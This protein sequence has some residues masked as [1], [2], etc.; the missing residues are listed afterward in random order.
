MRSEKYIQHSFAA[1]AAAAAPATVGAI[2]ITT[3]VHS[4]REIKEKEREKSASDSW[5]NYVITIIIS[6][7]SSVV[8]SSVWIVCMFVRFSLSFHCTIH[9]S[10]VL[11]IYNQTLNAE[12]EE[13][14]KTPRAHART[15]AMYWV[16]DKQKVYVDGVQVNGDIEPPNRRFSLLSFSRSPFISIVRTLSLTP[17]EHNMYT[18]HHIAQH[19]VYNTRKRQTL[20]QSVLRLL[21]CTWLCCVYETKVK[22]KFNFE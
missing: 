16:H 17:S 2:V 3:T 1:A 9:V 21:Y 6:W 7:F 11:Y 19:S 5:P 12:Y 15:H 14:E 10:S 4:E 18:T 20:I 13:R 8:S 22:W